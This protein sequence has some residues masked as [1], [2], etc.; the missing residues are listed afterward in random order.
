MDSGYVEKQFILEIK[1]SSGLQVHSYART[2]PKVY[3]FFASDLERNLKKQED[4]K[5][6]LFSSSCFFKFKL[7]KMMKYKMTKDKSRGV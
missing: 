7:R 3:E 5:N 2:K 4:E 1:G 6:I